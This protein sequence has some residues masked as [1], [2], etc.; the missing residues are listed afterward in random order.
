MSKYTF[1]VRNDSL[2]VRGTLPK[3]RLA[4]LKAS[5]CKWKRIVKHLKEDDAAVPPWDGGTETCGLCQIYYNNRDCDD[6]PVSRKT[7]MG[8]CVGTPYHKYQEAKGY[9][10]KTDGLEAAKA[11]MAFLKGLLPK[12]KE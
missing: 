6:C 11:E 9:V 4:A 12:K 1:S 8:G 7:G 5:I 10:D 3:S 2:V